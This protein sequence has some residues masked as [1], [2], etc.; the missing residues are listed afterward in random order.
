ML[1]PWIHW[2]LIKS[3]SLVIILGLH[4]TRL[5]NFLSA[6]ILPWLIKLEL[7]LTLQ[8]KLKQ[9]AN[10]DILGFGYCILTFVFRNVFIALSDIADLSLSLHFIIWYL[11]YTLIRWRIICYSKI[12][13]RMSQLNILFNCPF[14][15][16]AVP[17]TFSFCYI[18]PS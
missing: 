16:L 1:N 3:L 11:L 12:K 15:I 2:K 7:S 17:L 10:I 18:K 6:L 9:T 5:M 14:Y 8:V 13:I 4:K